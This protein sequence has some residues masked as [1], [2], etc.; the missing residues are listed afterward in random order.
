MIIANHISWL[1]IHA[2]NSILPLTFIAKSD[3]KNWPVLGYL[4]SKGNVL[5]IERGKR[6]HATRIVDITTRHL[7]TGDNLCLFPEG[8]TT[9]G[10]TIMPFKGSV[11]QSAIAAQSTI[12]PLAIRYPHP[13][14]G[15]NT[16]LAYAGETTMAQSMR[17]LLRQKRPVVELHFL[18]PIV[19]AELAEHQQN[20][21]DL[22]LH[23]QSL[24]TQK[25]AL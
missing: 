16:A 14:G 8:T 17:Q 9:D 3:I 12:W 5:F 15:I 7:K 13:A 22:T 19:T 21:R 2:I 11:V 20:R 23:I 10:T 1:D 25:L 4:I 18:T 24:I 6:H